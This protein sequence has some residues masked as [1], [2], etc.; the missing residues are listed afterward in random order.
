M[1]RSLYS[2][3]SGLRAH[4]TMMDVTGN[5]I[6]NVNTVGYKAAATLFQDTMSQTVATGGK[7]QVDA[8]LVPVRGGINAAQIGLGVKLADIATNFRQ[9]SQQP[10]GVG[11]DLMIQGDG[12]FVLDE[13]GQTLYTRSGGFHF[14]SD[15]NLVAPNGA[16]VMGYAAGVVPAPGVALVPMTLNPASAVP[17]VTTEKMTSYTISP[18]GEIIGQFDDDT[19]R[20]FGQIATATFVNPNGLEKAGNST[21]RSNAAVTGAADLGAAGTGGRG[22]MTSGSLEMSNVDLAQEFTNLIVAQRGFQANSRVITTSD[23]LLQELVNLKR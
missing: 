6:S 14:D 20:S 8:A 7:P 15:Q 21:Y 10:T 3:I 16:F 12:F 23:E 22:P 19:P 11:T 13:A 4:Q 5:N 18:T 1:L 9:G 17:A 2:G